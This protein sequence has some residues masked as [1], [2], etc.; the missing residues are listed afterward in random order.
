MVTIGFLTNKHVISGAAEGNM[1]ERIGFQAC[2]DH[3]NISEHVPALELLSS[4]T[5]FENDANTSGKCYN[6]MYLL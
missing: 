2:L 5:I 1:R 6:S 4:F 3:P